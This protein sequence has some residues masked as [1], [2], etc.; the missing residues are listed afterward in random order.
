MLEEAKQVLAEMKEVRAW[1]VKFDQ[2]Q[3]AKIEMF[4]LK[5]QKVLNQEL[6]HFFL[7]S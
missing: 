2:I 7:D 3:K 1:Q 6:K 5:G 4:N